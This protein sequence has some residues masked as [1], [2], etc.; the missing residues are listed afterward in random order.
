[1]V[2]CGITNYR[3][4]TKSFLFFF[5]LPKIEHH[6]LTKQKYV[7]YIYTMSETTQI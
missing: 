6:E 4:D 1:M 5:W 2:M 3:K 7:K